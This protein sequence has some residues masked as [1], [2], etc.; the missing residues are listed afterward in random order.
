MGSVRPLNPELC[1]G[2]K[3]Y[4]ILLLVPGNLQQT[5]LDYLRLSLLPHEVDA[6][7]RRVSAA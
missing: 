7:Y 3:Y 6:V 2:R 4:L 1:G 5:Q